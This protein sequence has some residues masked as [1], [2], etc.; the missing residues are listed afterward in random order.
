MHTHN[1]LHRCACLQESEAGRV[2]QSDN[3]PFSAFDSSDAL[4][5]NAGT[6]FSLD[7]V[8]FKCAEYGQELF[9][10][11]ESLQRQ[12]S[13]RT[14]PVQRSCYDSDRLGVGYRG[15]VRRTKNGKACLRWGSVRSASPMV[16]DANFPGRCDL[17]AVFARMRSVL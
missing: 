8:T 12:Q 17:P 7:N 11:V 16:N 4:P 5:F 14:P 15:T 10:A 13:R 2:A 9:A 6:T 1:F 3:H